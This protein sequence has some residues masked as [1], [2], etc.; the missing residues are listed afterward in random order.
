ML[1][2]IALL[3]YSVMG[4]LHAIDAYN[5]LK[6]IDEQHPQDIPYKP[7][8]MATSAIITGAVWPIFPDRF[9]FSTF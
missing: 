1:F 5:M 3:G 9:K 2:K 7:L 6:N 4:T 8:V